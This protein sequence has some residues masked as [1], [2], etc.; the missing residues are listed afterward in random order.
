MNN[1]VNGSSFIF[2]FFQK[3]KKKKKRTV[4]TFSNFSLSFFFQLW[5]TYIKRPMVLVGP[6]LG[7]AVAIDFSVHYPEAVSMF[8][9]CEFLSR[10]YRFVSTF[11]Y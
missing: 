1:G 8:N 2:S 6:S 4:D 5:S 3:K 11:Y 10:F 7:S 9:D